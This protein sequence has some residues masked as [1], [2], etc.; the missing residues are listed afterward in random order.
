MID[1]SDYTILPI[2][3]FVVNYLYDIEIPVNI[4]KMTHKQLKDYKPNGLKEIP[5]ND[6]CKDDLISG[7]VLLVKSFSQKEQGSNIRAYFNPRLILAMNNQNQNRLDD[8]IMKSLYNYS[9][10]DDGYIEDEKQKYVKEYDGE[11]EKKAA[12]QQET[13]SYARK[14]V[15]ENKKHKYGKSFVIPKRQW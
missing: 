2:S 9:S 13:K 3:K 1:F 14:R 7:R 5:L 15:L 8:M 4:D 6:V 12:M 10:L 11:L